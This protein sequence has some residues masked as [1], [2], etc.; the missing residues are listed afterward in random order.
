MEDLDGG[1][2]ELIALFG[3]ITTTD[4]DVLVEQFS[5]VLQVE[6]GVARFFLEASSWSVETAVHA[7]LASVG[8]GD[9]LDRSRSS[10]VVD[11]APLVRLATP[12]QASFLGDLSPL[13][14]P[15]QPLQTVDMQWAFRNTGSDFWPDNTRL[16]FVEGDPMGGRPA[17][18]V[19]RVAPGSHVVVH[20]RLRAPQRE[21]TYTGIWR[22]VTPAGYFGES[23]WAIA[24]V[25]GPP[26]LL[27]PAGGVPPLLQ[28]ADGG[29][30][31][32]GNGHYHAPGPGVASFGSN[33]SGGGGGDDLDRRFDDMEL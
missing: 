9:A 21:G 27:P 16:V 26:V 32:P 18:E 4:H 30:A 14:N 23:L 10:G 11:A 20:Q 2:D 29:G 5:R 28:P 3:K 7:Y 1:A 24:T 25:S 17:L 12:P 13:C 31:G 19:P 8:G 6:P 15:V 33:S 22:L